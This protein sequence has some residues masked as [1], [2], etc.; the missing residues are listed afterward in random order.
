MHSFFGP[1]QYSTVVN[2]TGLRF[3]SGPGD[4]VRHPN[5]LKTWRVDH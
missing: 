3:L 4:S 2:W 1:I 5:D